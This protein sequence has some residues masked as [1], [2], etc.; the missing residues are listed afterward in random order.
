MWHVELKIVVVQVYNLEVF[1]LNNIH[2][3]D[4]QIFN[5]IFCESNPI[6]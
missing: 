5:P 2:L 4:R 1:F 3:P 6:F